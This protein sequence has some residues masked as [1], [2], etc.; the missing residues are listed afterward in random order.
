MNY[1]NPI[2]AIYPNGRGFGFALMTSAKEPIDCR[3]LELSSK[4]QKKYIKR[5]RNLLTYYRPT[6]LIIEDIKDAKKS[7]RIEELQEGIQSLTSELNLK[8]ARYSRTQT[9]EVFASF[10]AHTRYEIAKCIYDWFPNMGLRLPKVK[11]VW[12][13]DDFDMGGYD[14]LSLALTHYYLQE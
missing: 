6:L 8:V 11:K 7:K 3:S 1:T 9:K 12:E 2:M 4:S 5:I 14:A 13:S 10:N